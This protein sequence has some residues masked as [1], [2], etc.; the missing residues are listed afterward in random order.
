MSNCASS[1]KEDL[2]DNLMGGKMRTDEDRCNLIVNYLPQEISDT[3][4]H[5]LFISHG[6]IEN[7]RVIRDK[8]T[9][10]GLGYGFVRFKLEEG[11]IR[12]IENNNGLS[13]GKK[14]LKVSVARPA[15]AD[16]KNC[17][18]Y[19][20]NLPKACTEKG[21]IETF[22][23]FGDIIE[24]RVLSDE[25]SLNKGVAFVQFSSRA[26]ATHALVLNGHMLPMAERP[27]TVKFAEARH[28]RKERK[29][30]NSKDFQR[31]RE[32][33]L[34]GWNNQLL[35]VHTDPQQQ[36]GH[37]MGQGVEWNYGLLTPQQGGMMNSPMISPHL[38][39]GTCTDYFASG[40]HAMQQVALDISFLPT[41]TDIS[42]LHDL[43]A[44]CGTIIS[45]QLYLDSSDRA[46]PM[47]RGAV[48]MEGIDA[49][50]CAVRYVNGTVLFEGCRPLIV[51]ITGM[52]SS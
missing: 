33:Y 42:L 12:A 32:G 25:S 51:T 5:D 44:P 22:Q 14:T 8:I 21:V 4:L 2:H 37:L 48:V 43:F 52:M 46:K 38:G 39:D 45:A 17:K 11:A 50:N 26:E 47:A 36:Y 10:K 3:A 49:A 20:T 40:K 24:C 13:L 7:A 31:S 28:R 30:S 6:E 35:S 29:R 34:Q 41:E 19:I 1:S 15:S 23:P 27:L 18:L 16:I 9:G